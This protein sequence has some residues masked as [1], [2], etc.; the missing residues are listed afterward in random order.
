M[1]GLKDARPSSAKDEC[2]WAETACNAAHSNYYVNLV[3]V[4]IRVRV[5][6]RRRV[7]LSVYTRV[8][9]G[10]FCLCSTYVCMMASVCVWLLCASMS[11]MCSMC[12]WLSYRG[13]TSW[14]ETACI[15]RVRS[16]C[17]P[18]FGNPSVNPL[19]VSELLY[20]CKNKPQHARTVIFKPMCQT[21]V[22]CFTSNYLVRFKA[23]HVF[24][25][26]TKGGVC[27]CVRM[28]VSDVSDTVVHW[29]GLCDIL[30]SFAGVNDEWVQTLQLGT[31]E[32][33]HTQKLQ[34]VYQSE[35]HTCKHMYH[36][37][38]RS[39]HLFNTHKHICKAED[40][41]KKYFL[42]KN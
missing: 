24:C 15:K 6:E 42:W 31:H 36:K 39:E 35:M 8:H 13:L 37:S 34:N 7:Y 2:F 10:V 40:P 28:C 14:N 38:P 1:C 9:A 16:R 11:D 4:F 25:K 5:C 3:C 21:N 29:H 33:V 32:H 12:V 17:T 26:Q 22:L 27:V 41:S 18:R 30:Q 19:N 20:R 23:L